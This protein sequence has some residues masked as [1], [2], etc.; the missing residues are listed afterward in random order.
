MFS[1]V[2]EVSEFY[3]MVIPP[4]REAIVDLGLP[5]F[6]GPTCLYG[7]GLLLISPLYTRPV[8]LSHTP[9]LCSLNS[10]NREEGSCRAWEQPLWLCVRSS[11]RNKWFTC[12]LPCLLGQLGS[13]ATDP[14]Q[15]CSQPLCNSGRPSQC[16]SRSSSPAHSFPQEIHPCSPPSWEPG[17]A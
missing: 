11:S 5:V 4:K 10:S 1:F 3:R 12:H 9:A 17:P 13:Y 6:K 15:C 7:F 2:M 8:L 16:Q 14:S